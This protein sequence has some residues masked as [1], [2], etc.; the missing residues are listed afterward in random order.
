M[1]DVKFSFPSDATAKL[2]TVSDDVV[3]TATKKSIIRYLDDAESAGKFSKI[4]ETDY[5]AIR[6][7]SVH[8]PDADSITLGKYNAEVKSYISEANKTGSSYFDLSNDWGMIQQKY[9]LTD[10]EMFEYFNKPFI[11]DAVNNGKI[12]NFSH[13]PELPAYKGSY[14]EQEWNYLKTRGYNKLILNGDGW[15]AK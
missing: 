15:I 14:L 9:N 7:Q 10:Q 3:D 12:I 8:N 13:N 4:P 1:N 2:A 6:N 11:D 5:K